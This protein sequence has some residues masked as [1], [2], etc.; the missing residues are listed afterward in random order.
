CARFASAVAA[1]VAAGM[2]V[3][4]LSVGEPGIDPSRDLVVQAIAGAAK[5]GV[6]TTVAAGNEFDSVGRGSIGSPGSASAAITAAAAS[7]SDLIAYFSS[8]GPTPI[9]LQ[10]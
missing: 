7:K 9:G 2:D 5:A 8:S 10:F 6:V 1:A 4:N 3:I